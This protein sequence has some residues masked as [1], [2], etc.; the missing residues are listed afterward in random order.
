VSL[1][2]GRIASVIDITQ[3]SL[4]CLSLFFL[5]DLLAGFPVFHHVVLR[6]VPQLL[7]HTVHLFHLIVQV[8]EF[9]IIGLAAML[10]SSLLILYLWMLAFLFIIINSQGF[11][12]LF[13]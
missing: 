8:A 5:F 2:L 7:P 11:E 10:T 3:V 12:C 6:Q 4:L 13:V 9:V 1:E